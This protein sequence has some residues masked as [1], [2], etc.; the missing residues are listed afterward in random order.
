MIVVKIWMVLLSLAFL[1]FG[2]LIYFRGKYHLINGFS[3][4]YREGRKTKD[5]ARKVGLCELIIGGILAVVA[6]ILFVFC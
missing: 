5:Y 3:A 6:I 4:A 2:Y 1:S